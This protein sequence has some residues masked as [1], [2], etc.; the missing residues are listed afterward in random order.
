[1]EANTEY[2]RNL[3]QVIRAESPFNSI[4]EFNIKSLSEEMGYIEIIQS[5]ENG[6]AII[7]N[8]DV[9]LA[10]IATYGQHHYHKLQISFE[11][12]L[13]AIS[14]NSTIE[15]IDYGCGQALATFIF[16]DFLRSKNKAVRVNSITL[17]EPSF[18]ALNRGKLHL[19]HL[20]RS[21]SD[22]RSTSIRSIQKS[23]NDIE[24]NDISTERT[25]IKVHLFSNI[26][27]V[28]GIDLEKL[29]TNIDGSQE[30]KNLFVCVSPFNG[31]RG[32][33]TTFYNLFPCQNKEYFQVNESPIMRTM[34]DIQHRENR[35]RQITMVQ[36]I[37][38]CQL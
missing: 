3:G 15:I 14:E 21:I 28:D 12:L 27:D 18:H 16:I 31:S 30:G 6:T 33:L 5:L 24:T 10:Y 26:L 8:Y 38:S 37:F 20:F 1:M 13:G 22:H 34:F 17:I 9:L 36:W 7:D 19:H 11:A 4:Y 25:T 29:Y 23:L 32:R 2:S 35:Q